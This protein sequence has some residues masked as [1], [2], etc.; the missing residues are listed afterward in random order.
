SK[1]LNLKPGDRQ[2]VELNLRL[3]EILDDRLHEPSKALD[4][5]SR[6][7]ELD[8]GSAAALKR[9]LDLQLRAGD[10]G[11]AVE[12]AQRLVRA[13]SDRAGRAE[14]LG[15]L[16]GLELTRGK[17][18]EALEAFEQAVALAGVETDFANE[19]KQLISRQPDLA[20]WSRYANAL[21]K[22]VDQSGVLSEHLGSS[23]AELGRIQSRELQLVPQA[24]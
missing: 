18:A 11:P 21:T 24:I 19:M 2:V 23:Y 9:M 12:T 20:A 7:L 5:L 15:K 1:L 16:A 10:T 22:Y 17:T 13:S 4:A 3:A 6:V 8:A 14:A